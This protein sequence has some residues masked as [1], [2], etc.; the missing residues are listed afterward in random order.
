[1][2]DNNSYYSNLSKNNSDFALDRLEANVNE[3]NWDNLSLN[4]ND[5][6]IHLLFQNEDKINL[7]NFALNQ[8]PRAI[9]YM[10]INVNKKTI[11]PI[12][13]KYPI[14]VIFV[15]LIGMPKVH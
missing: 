2:S 8:N 3:I 15:T 4:T 11:I 13:V 7:F 6:A 5:R 12:R 9:S 10:K 14:F 1:M